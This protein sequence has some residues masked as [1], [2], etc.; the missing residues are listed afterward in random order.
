MLG[1]R[2]LKLLRQ[3]THMDGDQAH[4]VLDAARVPI[5][6][7]DRNGFITYVNPAAAGLFGWEPDELIGRAHHET[8]HHSRA[9]RT[10]YPADDCPI[11]LTLRTGAEQRGDDEPF[12]R[13]DGTSISL[14]YTCSP[15]YEAGE[16][17][18]AVV[19]F[20]GAPA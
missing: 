15:L 19:V 8:L 20:A 9:D 13:R 16:L 12:W 14:S 10:P 3:Q 4:L 18:G 11:A 1:S 17:A 5:H 7:L 6:T 2:N